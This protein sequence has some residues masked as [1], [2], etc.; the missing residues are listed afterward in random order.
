MPGGVT[1]RANGTGAL[2]QA[3]EAYGLEALARRTGYSIFYLREYKYYPCRSVSDQLA[4]AL[5][6]AFGMDKEA[7]VAAWLLPAQRAVEAES[8]AR[9]EEGKRP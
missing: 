9:Q 7:A 6:Q 1:Y 8:V 3:M 4:T 2:W 5:A